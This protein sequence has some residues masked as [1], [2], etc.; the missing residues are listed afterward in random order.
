[1]RVETIA[2]IGC[3]LMGRGIAYASALGGFRTLLHDV[4]ADALERALGRIRQDLDEGLARG[5]LTPEGAA[6]A[7]NR[8]V[9]EQEL[10]TAGTEADFVVEAVPEFLHRSLG[11]KYRPAPLLVQYVKAGRLGRKV[12]RGVYDYP[13]TS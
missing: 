11:E 10:E 13:T 4:S 1:L 2:V 7:L 9:P 5:R 6:A 3:G 8:L 12:G